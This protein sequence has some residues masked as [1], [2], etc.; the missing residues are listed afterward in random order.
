MI[1]TAHF[2]VWGGFAK[3]VISLHSSTWADR[4][5]ITLTRVKVKKSPFRVGQIYNNP[6]F[7]FNKFVN[8][9]TSLDKNEISECPKNRQFRI[10][11][12]RFNSL[13][14]FRSFSSNVMFRPLS[15]IESVLI[16]LRLIEASK[17]TDRATMSTKNLLFVTK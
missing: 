13:M 7:T 8:L 5:T 10:S 1:N 16:P 12:Y 6:R 2:A 11:K 3:P 4:Q 9:L 14:M 17:L 15:L